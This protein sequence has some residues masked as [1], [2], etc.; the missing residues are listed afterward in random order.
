MSAHSLQ[1]T[2]RDEDFN[3]LASALNAKSGEAVHNRLYSNGKDGLHLYR[4]PE[5]KIIATYLKKKLNVHV[6]GFSSMNKKDLVDWISNGLHRQDAGAAAG[7]RE[8]VPRAVPASSHHHSS[9]LSSSQHSHAA[10]FE[11][12]A[13]R[14]TPNP[15]F[16]VVQTL[17]VKDVMASQVRLSF[18][19]EQTWN[20]PFHGKPR[21]VHARIFEPL[22]AWAQQGQRMKETAWVTTGGLYV[23]NN[24]VVGLPKKRKQP[25]IAANSNHATPP[26]VLD[27]YV[28]AGHNSVAILTAGER[29]WFIVQIGNVREVDEVQEEILRQGPDT[30]AYCGRSILQQL[31][32]ESESDDIACTDLEV[33]LRCPLSMLRINLPAK[34][35]NCNHLQCF[36]LSTFLEY[37]KKHSFWLCPNCHKPL[38]P[39]ELRVCSLFGEILN[40][41]SSEA[42]KCKIMPDGSFKEVAEG[43]ERLAEEEH[44][45]AKKAKLETQQ[46]Q[47]Q[48]QQDGNPG[49]D[50][51]AFVAGS[52]DGDSGQGNDSLFP[53]SDF[54][55]P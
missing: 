19:L 45:K 53:G 16:E 36:D 29:F 26:V 50:M 7:K 39:A 54:L 46:Q 30:G 12:I 17:A 25:H 38:P 27:R 6:T 33:S 47:Q 28:Y 32:G 5:L 49:L 24:Q 40:S 2:L 44:R 15:F 22:E 52:A 48:Q 8:R 41:V 20:S 10:H 21:S 4:V 42:D 35:R 51:L 1:P 37:A 14:I 55:L 3:E 18:T 9:H 13:A 23:N 11:L 43:E 34:G 31:L